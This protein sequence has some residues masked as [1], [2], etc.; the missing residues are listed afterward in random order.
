MKIE[1][2]FKNI[3]E[4]ISNVMEAYTTA[5]FIA[6]EK[7]EFMQLFCF[8]SFCKKIKKKCIIKNGEGLLGWV[9]REQKNVWIG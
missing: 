7:K 1:N 5:L 6:D 4:L 2:K 8:Q 3:I 9:L